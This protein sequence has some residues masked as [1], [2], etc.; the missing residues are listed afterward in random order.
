MSDLVVGDVVPLKSM[1]VTIH[2]GHGWLDYKLPK[3]KQFVL[4]LLGTEDVS[5]PD[6]LD[7]AEKLN[8]MGWRFEP[9]ETLK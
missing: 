6:K 3:G 7:A 5:G 9:Q 2:D 4:L 8:E 1:R